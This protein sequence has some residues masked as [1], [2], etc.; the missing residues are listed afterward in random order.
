MKRW[1]YSLGCL[2]VLLFG[3]GSEPGAF[4]AKKPAPPA[5]AVATQHPLATEAALRVLRQGGNAIDAALAAALTLAVVEPYNSG[6]GGGGM[7][8]V[9]SEKKARAFDFRETAPARAHARTFLEAPNPEASKVGPLSIAVP[10][11]VAGL[12][13]LHRQY[14]KLPWASLFDEAIQ[15]AEQGFR[16]DAELRRRLQAKAECLLRDYHS[17]QV[18]GPLLKPE[19]VGNWIQA[20]L[21]QTLKQLRDGGAPPFYQGSIGA[22]L[23]ANLQGK[24]ALLQLEDLQNYRALERKPVSASYS[25]GKIWGIPPPSAGGIGILMGMNF[26]EARLKKDKGGWAA[27]GAD[28]LAAAMAEMFRIRNQELGD[29]DFNPGMPLKDWLKKGGNTSHLSVMDGEGKA[30][31]LTTTLNL[32][33]GSCVTAGKTGILMNDEMDDFSTRPGEANDFGLVQS[34]KNKV[35]A[36]KR[37]LSSMSPTLVTKGGHALAAL[38]SP[39]GPRIM[40]SVFQVLAW[41]FFGGETWSK[42]VAEERLHYQ[43]KPGNLE[44]ET[45]TSRWGNVQAV[46][47]DPKA[48][49]FQAVSDPR[50]EGRAAVLGPP[51]GE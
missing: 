32:S 29:P 51:T 9:W 14:G 16:P 4:A 23:I 19:R 17:A 48:K 45:A 39:G 40:S 3:A 6:L 33:F 20:D 38:G 31:A 11:A 8:L 21:A 7:A 22:E 10:G 13:L 2:L 42:A 47:Y 26:L 49:T 1:Y 46:A 35:E 30:V 43:G 41:H 12:E 18:Y 37:P 36:G 27:Q 50:G 15:H 44:K 28:W 24:G 34:E 5:G 25:F